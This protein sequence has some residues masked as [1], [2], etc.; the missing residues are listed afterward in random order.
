MIGVC[1]QAPQYAFREHAVVVTNLFAGIAAPRG[2][3]VW[4]RPLSEMT[5]SIGV[6]L[7]GLPT[8]FRL[9]PKLS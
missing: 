5:T 1:S 6:P 3:G 8:Q 9:H 7:A 4:R 2:K